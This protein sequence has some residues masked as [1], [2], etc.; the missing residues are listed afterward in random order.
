[1]FLVPNK[2]VYRYNVM[3]WYQRRIQSGHSFLQ[4]AFWLLFD[5]DNKLLLTDKTLKDID[6]TLYDRKSDV[7]RQLIIIIMLSIFARQINS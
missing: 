2:S 3:Y 5:K 4:I 7:V 6:Q 1:M